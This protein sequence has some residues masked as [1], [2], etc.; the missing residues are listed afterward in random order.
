MTYT[1]YVLIFWKNVNFFSVMHTSRDSIFGYERQIWWISHRGKFCHLGLSTL[2]Y[3][4]I[5]ILYNHVVSF[6]WQ[7]SCQFLF[8]LNWHDWFHDICINRLPLLSWWI[9]NIPCD[10]FNCFDSHTKC[11]DTLNSLMCEQPDILTGFSSAHFCLYH[12]NLIIMVDG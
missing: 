6:P 11:L 4:T 1:L 3:F 7:F 12:V 2:F 5:L 10:A 8:R 9:P